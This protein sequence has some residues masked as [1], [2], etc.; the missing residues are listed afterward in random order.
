LLVG[1]VKN[2]L[3][4]CIGVASISE[5]LANKSTGEFHTMNDATLLSKKGITEALE[6][7]LVVLIGSEVVH[8]NEEIEQIEI[9]QMRIDRRSGS[10]G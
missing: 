1:G 10:K 6:H 5:V 4:V 3:Y 2:V 7:M 9:N 8:A